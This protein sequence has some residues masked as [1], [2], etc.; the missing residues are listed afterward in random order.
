MDTLAGDPPGWVTISIYNPKVEIDEVSGSLA[1][2]TGE[3]FEFKFTPTAVSTSVSPTGK[4]W[5]IARW[6]EISP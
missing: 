3:T 2:A 1:I 4:L 6:R 5:K